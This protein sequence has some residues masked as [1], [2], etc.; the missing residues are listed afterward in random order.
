MTNDENQELK[1]DKEILSHIQHRYD[2]EERRFQSVDT[3]ISSMIGV[4]A[5]IFTIQAS[6]FINILSNSKPDIC[7][8]V[9][10]IF[11]LALY[12][13]SIYYFI[14]SHYFK[15]FSATPKPSFL[16]EEGAKKESEHTIVKDMIAL[17]SDCINDNEKLIENKTNI[18]KKGFSF[19]IYG[20]CLS[21]IFLLCFLLELFV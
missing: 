18:A 8:I 17:Y 11:S 15:K 20:G 3:K 6:L 7:L 16:M 5:V 9:L 4:L 1:R 10:F 14:K 21:F 13:I 12:L 19:L 2:E